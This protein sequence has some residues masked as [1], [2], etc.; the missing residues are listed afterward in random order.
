MP[1]SILA[2]CQSFELAS[3]GTGRSYRI[4]LAG[5][6]PEDGGGGGGR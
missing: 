5:G 1:T 4:S 6:R 2:A 3:R